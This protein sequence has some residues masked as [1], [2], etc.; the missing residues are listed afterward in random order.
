M[1]SNRCFGHQISPL[2]A[3]GIS[4]FLS[5]QEGGGREGWRNFAINYDTIG[6]INNREMGVTGEA[7]LKS[8]H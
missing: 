5:F 7:T 8:L 3:N 2:D 1:N 4:C 6:G